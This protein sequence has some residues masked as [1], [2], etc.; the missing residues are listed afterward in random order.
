MPSDGAHW[1]TSS[2]ITKVLKHSTGYLAHVILTEAEA[3]TMLHQLL[4][5]AAAWS[6]TGHIRAR[7]LAGQKE[8]CLV[9]FDGMD[10]DMVSSLAKC[11]RATLTATYTDDSALVLDLVMRQ[12]TVISKN[13]A[14]AD[15]VAHHVIRRVQAELKAQNRW[16]RNYGANKL[17]PAIPVLVG[18]ALLFRAQPGPVILGAVFISVGFMRILTLPALMIADKLGPKSNAHV[19]FAGPGNVPRATGAL[20]LVVVGAF[21][22]RHGFPGIF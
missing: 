18:T 10:G 3:L 1:N 13:P 22:G 19:S 2:V 9:A 7:L 4:E 12:W 16:W 5:T 15:S 11:H 21:L 20:L 14:M 6:L 8:Q 17:G